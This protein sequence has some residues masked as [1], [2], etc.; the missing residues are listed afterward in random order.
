MKKRLFT[1]LLTLSIAASFLTGCGSKIHATNLVD[2]K[3]PKNF[4]KITALSEN[5]TIVATDF[6]IRLFQQAKNGEENAL[7]S[8]L[9]VL[10]ALSMAANGAKEETL[11]QME[12]T[13][14]MPM[15]SLNE[16]LYSYIHSLPKADDCKFH[17]ANSI[18]L[19]D[20]KDFSVDEKFLKTT[21]KYYDAEV[22]QTAF[23]DRT[24]ADMNHW[25]SDQTNDMIPSMID[26]I[27]PEAYLYL[28]NALS[29]DSKWS[30][31]YSSSSVKDGIFTTEDGISQDI[32]MMYSDEY[33]YIEDEYA[34]GFLKPYSGYSYAFVALLPKEGISLTD[35]VNS[36]A[37]EHLHHL[38]TNAED[39]PVTTGI[40]KFETEFTVDLIPALQT[41][42]I[43]H[44]FDENRADFTGIGS[45][46]SPRD[47][48]FINRV[49]HK[50]F[51]AVD[52]QGTKA[53]A[54]TMV[55][56]EKSSAPMD[57]EQPKEVI[58]DR[59][60]LYMIV[61]YENRFP[62]FIGTADDMQ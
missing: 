32:E 2:G 62:I 45:F 12:Q 21:A 6:A 44:A 37:G 50:S 58:L 34:T 10:P 41:L 24:L 14:R 11:T 22:Y 18:W 1:L 25:V 16:Y 4:L 9:S 29:F 53:G 28:L 48:L 47:R 30:S 38:L 33:E 56:M 57:P 52:E 17:L 59:P 42:G 31:I 35:Y 26:Q 46:D 27:D 15:N 39:C 36:L 49:L 61:D 13:F 20:A 5:D 19:R 7:L 3:E 43:Q 60:F 55:D 54:A 23:D 40:P 51:L 8:P